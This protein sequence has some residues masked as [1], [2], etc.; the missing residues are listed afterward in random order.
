M[1]RRLR[2]RGYVIPEAKLREKEKDLKMLCN[3][4]FANEGKDHEPRNVG[5]L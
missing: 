1:V 5:H 3:A 2:V 4:N